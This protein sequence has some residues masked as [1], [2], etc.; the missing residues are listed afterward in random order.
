MED[1]ADDRFVVVTTVNL[2]ELKDFMRLTSAY[3][4]RT[5]LDKSEFDAMMGEGFKEDLRRP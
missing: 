4:E 5:V 2:D 3:T 1:E